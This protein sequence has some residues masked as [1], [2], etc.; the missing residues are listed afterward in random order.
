[1]SSCTSPRLQSPAFAVR[2][3]G[4]V[5]RRDDYDIV[6]QTSGAGQ[7]LDYVIVRTVGDR[8]QSVLFLVPRE[9][10]VWYLPQ[11]RYRSPE[12]V[13]PR[14]VPCWTPRTRP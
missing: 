12:S 2:L 3:Y 11:V 5:C 7:F 4:T 6:G 8:L 13:L 9:I 1:M 14:Y 10:P